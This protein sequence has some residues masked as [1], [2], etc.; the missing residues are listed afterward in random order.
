M[1]LLW[2]QMVPS[3]VIQLQRI[4]MKNL[5][6][7]LCTTSAILYTTSLQGQG[8]NLSEGVYLREDSARVGS[9]MVEYYNHE[10]MFIQPIPIITIAD[11]DVISPVTS[12]NQQSQFEVSLNWE[13]SEKWKDFASDNVG[14]RVAFTCNGIV[15]STMEIN[16]EISN[17]YLQ[18]PGNDLAESEL[19][20]IRNVWQRSL[21]MMQMFKTLEANDNSTVA[22]NDEENDGEYE[23]NVDSAEEATHELYCYCEEGGWEE[24]ME[25]AQDDINIDNY[26]SAILLLDC[27]LKCNPL[28]S[29]AYHKRANAHELEG[30][31]T[32]ALDDYNQAIQLEPQNHILYIQRGILKSD[33]WNPT[34]AITDYEM[35][36]RLSPNNADALNNIGG[37][38]T[39]A[40][41]YTEAI[42]FFDLAIEADSTHA[43]AH[44][45]KALA[46]Y[47]DGKTE[48]ACKWWKLAEKLGDFSAPEY[49]RTICE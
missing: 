33:N 43:F 9:L 37:V 49:L 40:Q 13:D 47:Y 12:E 14:K 45:N 17:G 32:K 21:N 20:E 8:L 1:A 22:H 10:P 30:N 48:E 11:I 2:V 28:S 36:L 15:F 41:R 24:F 19:K 44:G 39:G 4:D 16:F 46:L 6:I 5:I 38:H 25:M 7:F 18:V 42:Q 23:Q 26:N 29:L 34:G 27:Y 31:F 35:A 3:F